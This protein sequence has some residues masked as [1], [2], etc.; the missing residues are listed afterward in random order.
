MVCYAPEVVCNHEV[1]EFACL[2]AD[3]ASRSFDPVPNDHALLGRLTLVWGSHVRP[4]VGA[5][6]P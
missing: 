4:N 2:I 1:D 3:Y 5:K 6:R